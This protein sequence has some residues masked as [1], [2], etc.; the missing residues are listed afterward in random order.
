MQDSV[1]VQHLHK[2]SSK[3]EGEGK[4]RARERE[5][6]EEERGKREAQILTICC[7]PG[8]T[9]KPGPFCPVTSEL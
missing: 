6:E 2:C 9:H 1:C 4:V 3:D 8:Q 7:V 5:E